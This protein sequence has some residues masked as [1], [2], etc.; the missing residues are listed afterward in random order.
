MRGLGQARGTLCGVLPLRFLRS[1]TA[2][3]RPDQDVAVLQERIPRHSLPNFFLFPPR[4]LLGV[5]SESLGQTSPGG[6]KASAV[7]V[8]GIQQS[9]T[10]RSREVVFVYLLIVSPRH[11]QL[12]PLRTLW[13]YTRMRSRRLRPYETHPLQHTSPGTHQA[14]HGHVRLRPRGNAHVYARSDHDSGRTFFGDPTKCPSPS[15]R[16]L[17]HSRVSLNLHLPSMVALRSDGSHRDAPRLA[18]IFSA[19]SIPSTMHVP[20]T[21]MLVPHIR[22]T[23]SIR[24]MFRPA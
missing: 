12:C 21:G 6:R 24:G 3:W 14:N 9:V 17:V 4:L 23:C 16:C 11:M 1:R 7:K 20:S 8:D 22:G 2:H 19:S 10:V 15:Q 13:S 18:Q 5:M